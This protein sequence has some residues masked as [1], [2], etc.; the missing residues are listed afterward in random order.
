MGGGARCGEATAEVITTKN[1]I[2]RLQAPRFFVE[3]D[4]VVLSATCTIT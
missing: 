2:I 4:E 3:K 1:L